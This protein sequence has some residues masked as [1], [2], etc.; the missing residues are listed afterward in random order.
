[1]NEI[2]QQFQ[3]IVPFRPKKWITL[4][5]FAKVFP[6]DG[7]SNPNYSEEE[8]SSM[9]KE[10]NNQ[11]SIMRTIGSHADEHNGP[12]VTWEFDPSIN[13]TR[14]KVHPVP[15][16]TKENAIQK[17][18]ELLKPYGATREHVLHLYDAHERTEQEKIY[19]GERAYENAAGVNGRQAQKDQTGWNLNDWMEYHYGT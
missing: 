8:K 16:E 10:W 13:D 11:D 19:A 15:E 7:S 5:D 18:L 14:R 2:G 3:G 1:M 9:L 4:Q 6:E 17:S 12:I